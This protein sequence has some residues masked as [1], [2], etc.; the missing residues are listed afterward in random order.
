MGQV[1]FIRQFMLKF[2][3]SVDFH[4]VGIEEMGQADSTVKD[5]EVLVSSRKVNLEG[6]APKMVIPF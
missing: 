4:S 1:C 5:T 2:L 6:H 3:Q